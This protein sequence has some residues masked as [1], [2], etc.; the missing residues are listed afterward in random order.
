ML[1]PLLKKFNELNL[2]T[3]E[4][5]IFGSGPL[6]V[7]GLKDWTDIDVVVLPEI[8]NN[9]KNNVDWETKIF[10]NSGIEYLAKDKIEMMKDWWPEQWDIKKLIEEA[11]IIDGLAFVKLEEVLKWKKMMNREKD[12]KDIEI[13]EHYLRQKI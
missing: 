6:C 13:I 11:D 9:F 7:R 1:H 10:E 4:Y 8:Y 2:S 5:V 3:R 12:I